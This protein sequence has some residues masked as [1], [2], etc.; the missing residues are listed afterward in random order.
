MSS[1][2]ATAFSDE[3]RAHWTA[4]A[5]SADRERALLRA[6]QAIDDCVRE[7]NERFLAELLGLPLKLAPVLGVAV[8]SSERR[9]RERAVGILLRA[10]D[11]QAKV[12][13]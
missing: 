4:V 11:R 10:L 1:L 9:Y 7:E 5:E 13:A 6:E 12:A 2:P 3:A 8:Y